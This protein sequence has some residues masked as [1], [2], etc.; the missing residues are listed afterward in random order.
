LTCKSRNIGTQ[1]V[2]AALATALA[3]LVAFPMKLASPRF[4]SAKD[5]V[6]AVVF[7]GLLVILFLCLAFWGTRVSPKIGSL[8]IGMAGLLAGYASSLLAYLAMVAALGRLSNLVSDGGSVAMTFLVP[9][10]TFGWL[11]GLLAAAF[12]PAE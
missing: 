9:L 5:A 8:S 2:C 4:H 7:W 6:Y 11:V 10:R 3:F 12:L 1:F